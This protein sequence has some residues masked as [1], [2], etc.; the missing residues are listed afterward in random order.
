MPPGI[1]DILEEFV[2]DLYGKSDTKSF[3]KT[4]F[5]LFYDKYAPGNQKRPLAQ[6]KGFYS[7][8]LL[9]YKQVLTQKMSQSNFQA[10]IVSS[11][12]MHAVFLAHSLSP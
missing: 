2:C 5:Q 11:I 4:R 7:S 6:I 1:A 8:R 3:N 10:A 12:V 9:P